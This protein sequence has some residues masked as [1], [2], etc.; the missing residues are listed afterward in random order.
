MPRACRLSA[1]ILC[2]DRLS[3]IGNGGCNDDMG[4]LMLGAPSIS[5]IFTK[6]QQH[7]GMHA[8]MLMLTCSYLVPAGSSGVKWLLPLHRITRGSVMHCIFLC[9]EPLPD[10]GHQYYL[11]NTMCEKGRHSSAFPPAE[12]WAVAAVTAKQ[13]KQACMP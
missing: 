9:H 7:A 11:C 6:A 8:Y 3:L 1:D 12:T 2:A 5:S 13:G 10:S 4:G